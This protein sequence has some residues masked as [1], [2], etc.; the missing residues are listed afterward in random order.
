MKN[1]KNIAEKIIKDT[2]IIK[3]LSILGDVRIVGSLNLDLLFRNDIDLLVFAQNPEESKA[4]DITKSL[5]DMNIF[6]TVG[7]SKNLDNDDYPKGYYWELI[8]IH[9]H[10]KW[11]FDIW[12]LSKEQDY[13]KNLITQEKE[14]EKV[15]ERYPDR[16]EVIL[17]IK[18]EFF[19][20][21][22]YSEGL[23]SIE[24]YNA[25]LLNNISSLEEF[26]V[27]WNNELSRDK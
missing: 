12:Y 21:V 27:Y 25:V 19:D 8:Y 2:E 11:K 5:L 16:R 6:Q 14:F 7:F 15:L 26:K 4:I 23:K 1:K 22:K 9:N 17:E 13:V 3:I 10:K 18:G 20:G 24:I